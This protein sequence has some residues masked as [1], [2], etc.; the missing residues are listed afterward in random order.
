MRV[1]DL[2]ALDKTSPHPLTPSPNLPI[3]LSRLST[4]LNHRLP[5]VE[6]NAEPFGEDVHVDAEF[7]E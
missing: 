7:V 1:I 6:L 2:I 3:T 5:A 4:W